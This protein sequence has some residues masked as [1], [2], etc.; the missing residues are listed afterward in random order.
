MI[1]LVRW[2]WGVELRVSGVGLSGL[3]EA[4]HEGYERVRCDERSMRGLSSCI[5]LLRE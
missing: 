2:V 1:V 4:F 5:S 3:Y